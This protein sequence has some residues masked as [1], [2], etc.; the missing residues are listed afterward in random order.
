ML[1]PVRSNL[2]HLDP[3][4]HSPLSAYPLAVRCA[5]P[6]QRMVPSFTSS[7]TV[8]HDE[9]RGTLLLHSPVRSYEMRRTALAY[10][11]TRYA[12]LR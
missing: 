10:G 2:I 9:M 1:L 5:V 6:T 3:A 7:Q 8:Y 12:V 11:P 4:R